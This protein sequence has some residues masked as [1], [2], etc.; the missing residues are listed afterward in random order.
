[1]KNMLRNLFLVLACGLGFALNL[2]AAPAIQIGLIQGTNTLVDG[3]VIINTNFTNIAT[4]LTNLPSSTG[5]TNDAIGILRANIAAGANIA[6]ATNSSG[7]ITI[8]TSG[9]FS[10]NFVLSQDGFGTNSTLRLVNI[11]GGTNS[12]VRNT[13]FGLGGIVYAGLDQRPTNDA[14]LFVYTNTFVG[15]GTAAPLSALHITQ[16][17]GNP[18]VTMQIDRPNGAASSALTLYKHRTD[19]GGSANIGVGFA[20]TTDNAAGTRTTAVNNFGILSTVTAGAEEGAWRIDLMSA[21][22]LTSKF[23][24]ESKGNFGLGFTGAGLFGTSAANTL[25]LLSA[26]PPSTSPADIT[27]LY[28]ADIGGVAGRAGLQIKD[29]TQAVVSI[30]TNSLFYRVR[31]GATGSTITNVPTATVSFNPNL[32]VA[33]SYTNF[34]FTLTGAKDGD[35]VA[36]RTPAGLNAGL[37]VDYRVTAADT[38]TGFVRNANATNVTDNTSRTFGA[39][40]IQH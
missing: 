39:T 3:R 1:M 38:V 13:D 23:I 18:T 29:E 16:A 32:V 7:Q 11:I 22:V 2:K 35:A 37:F 6:F 24:Y 4:L 27:Q 10:N 12:G 33:N 17:T 5:I 20:Y 8:S 40:L 31:L 30:G 25:G 19:A 9:T 34:T 36:G 15:I 14:A 26:T 28:S 21:G